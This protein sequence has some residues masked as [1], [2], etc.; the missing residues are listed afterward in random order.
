MRRW[1]STIDAWIRHACTLAGCNLTQ[2]EWD[3][4]V[5]RNRSYIRA[6]PDLP[7]GHG[8]PPNAPAATSHHLD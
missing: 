8:A 2:E 1:R 7:S 6:C 4:F 3:E 5:D